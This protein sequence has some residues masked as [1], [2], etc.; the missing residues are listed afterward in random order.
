MASGLPAGRPWRARH[1]ASTAPVVTCAACAARKASA[2]AL[3]GPVA[4]ARAR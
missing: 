4:R 1:A 2:A 3:S